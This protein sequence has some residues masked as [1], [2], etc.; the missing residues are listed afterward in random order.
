MKESFPGSGHNSLGPE[1]RSVLFAV[2]Q[3]LQRP[4]KLLLRKSSGRLHAPAGEHLICMMMV[5]VMIVVMA[6][7]AVSVMMM[8]MIMMV[9]IM[10]VVVMIVMVVIVMVVI[11]VVAAAA[12]FPVMMLMVMI[13]IIVVMMVVIVMGFLFQLTKLFFQSILMLHGFQDLCSGKL[14]PGSRND[15]CHRI[16]LS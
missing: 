6:A 2:I 4:L 16:M 1:D 8:V 11:M 12:V 13:V 7:A 15:R 14:I 9:V 3:C 5:M 10:I